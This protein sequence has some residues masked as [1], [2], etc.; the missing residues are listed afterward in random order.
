MQ[1]KFLKSIRKKNRE[2][3]GYL[4]EV[5]GA[6]ARSTGTGTGRTAA[7][8][9]GRLQVDGGEKTGGAATGVATY[10]AWARDV[11]GRGHGHDGA[12]GTGHGMAARRIWA[13]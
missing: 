3:G 11:H 7:A 13:A 2:A 4:G 12:A 1:L 6:G 8:T 9:G 5:D 10:G